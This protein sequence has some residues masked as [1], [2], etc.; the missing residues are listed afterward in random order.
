MTTKATPSD[1]QHR[2]SATFARRL[3]WPLAAAAV[4]GA[5]LA[6]GASRWQRKTS[7]LHAGLESAR[8]RIPTSAHEV[9][10]LDGLPPPVQR[11]LRIALKPGQAMISAAR[12][13]QVGTINLSASGERWK[14]FS[15]DQRIVVRRPGFDWDACIRAFPGATV[16]VHDAYVDG[17]G[18]LEASLWGLVPLAETRGTPEAAHGELIRF[19]AEAAWYPTALLPRQGVRWEAV[20]ANSARAILDDGATRATLLF[21]FDSA[22][23]VESA[24]AEARGAAVGK[25]VVLMPWEGRWSNYQM[26]DGMLVPTEGE[27]AWLTPQGRKPYWRGS[28]DAISF[29][30]EP[31]S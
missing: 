17:E 16:R 27:A 31:V 1:G 12:L 9:E 6:L 19:L 29:E 26:R 20:D 25:T 15:A 22:G 28:L 11:Y 3:A 7:R 14:P 2:V 4:V 5:G 21:T 13:R 24:R 23:L 18:L 8:I 10:S 30:Y